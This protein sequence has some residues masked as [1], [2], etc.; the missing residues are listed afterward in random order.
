M[1]GST[2][3]TI[4]ATKDPLAEARAVAAAEG[5]E[6]YFDWALGRERARNAHI[7]RERFFGETVRHSTPAEFLA[8]ARDLKATCERMRAESGPAFSD[9]YYAEG[10]R[11]RREM[12]REAA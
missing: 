11:L 12:Q 2:A 1:D 3:P 4:T 6:R 10:E 9:H 5:I 7:L 8:A